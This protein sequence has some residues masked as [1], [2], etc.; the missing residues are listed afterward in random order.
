MR[1]SLQTFLQL[2]DEP[3]PTQ[4]RVGGGHRTIPILQNRRLKRREVLGL[5]WLTQLVDKRAGSQPNNRAWTCSH[6]VT[7]QHLK[8]LSKAAAEGS[9]SSSGTR[10][11]WLSSASAQCHTL[12]RW[13]ASAGIPPLLSLSCWAKRS[14]FPDLLCPRGG[15]G[16][17]YLIQKADSL[18][19]ILMLGK[20]EGR[21]R[22]GQQMRWM[23]GITDSMDMSLSKLQ[24]IMKDREAWRAAV[25]RL[26]KDRHDLAPKQQQ[27][28]SGNH[29]LEIGP[30]KLAE[31]PPTICH[32]LGVKSSTFNHPWPGG[33]IL[34]GQLCPGS[35]VPTPPCG[36]DLDCDLFWPF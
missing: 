8:F 13:N 1:L 5:L 29:G 30:P 15:A 24:E 6:Q 23:D 32:C 11:R 25:H 3:S 18:E 16:S 7:H 26:A 14:S 31:D 17:G 9:R 10:L 22:W 33:N 21:R 27:E 28:G 36:L 19:K 34:G 35:S 20:T 12:T 2:S 4:R